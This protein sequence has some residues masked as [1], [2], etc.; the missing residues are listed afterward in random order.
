[1]TL[2]LGPGVD[3]VV[4]WGR[5]DFQILGI[6]ALQSLD[7]FDSESAREVRIF[8]VGVLAA[9]TARVAKDVDVWRPE[10]KTIKPAPVPVPL[11]LVILGACFFR[12]DS[13]DAADQLRVES[14]AETDRLR[15]YCRRA[16]RDAVQRV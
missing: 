2:G 8:A 12:D 14:S 5:Y 13:R 10:G 6:V 3:G 1:M 15:E 4:F 11:S 7:E 9:A 16:E